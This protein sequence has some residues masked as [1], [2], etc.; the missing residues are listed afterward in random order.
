MNIYLNGRIENIMTKNEV[1]QATYLQNKT[2][3]YSVTYDKYK[4][5]YYLYRIEYKKI[6]SGDNA[7]FENDIDI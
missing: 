3:K 4:N 2:P 7:D 6:K 1:I 5:K